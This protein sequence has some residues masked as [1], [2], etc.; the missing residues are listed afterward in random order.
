M[1][2]YAYGNGCVGCLFDHMS[3]PYEDMESAADDAADSLELT[4]AEREELA[5][6]GCLYFEPE[7]GREVGAQVVEIFEVDEDWQADF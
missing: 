7:R 6:D 1:T 4:E 2:L 3:G 5:A